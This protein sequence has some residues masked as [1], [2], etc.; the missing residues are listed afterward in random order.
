MIK[1]YVL[2]FVAYLVGATIVGALPPEFYALGYSIMVV[3]VG[4][5]TSILLRGKKIIVPHWRILEAIIVG[6]VGITF[7]IVLCHLQLETMVTKYLPGWLRP[8]SRVSYNPFEELSATWE[9]YTF[10]VFR[11]I[12]LSLLVPV[13]EEV[14]WRGFLARWIISEDWEDVK[15]ATFT[16]GSFWGVVGLFTLAHPEWLAAAT[17]CA[18]LSGLFYWK[19]DLWSCIVAHSVSNFAMGV[20]V[21]T[22]GTWWLW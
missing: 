15:L 14:F 8:G 9:I 1:P 12:G 7:W 20:Y 4:I 3:G 22:T 11:M 21:L 13:A 17:Y 19:K 5:A 16:W 18:L 10:I 2:P 6:L